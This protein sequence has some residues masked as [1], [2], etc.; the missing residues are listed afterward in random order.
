MTRIEAIL[1]DCQQGGY[2]TPTTTK[3][4]TM[5]FDGSTFDAARD[6]ARLGDQMAAVLSIM[7]D[8]KWRT[9]AGIASET[10]A[11]EASV[12]ARLRDLRKSRFGGHTVNREY[13]QRGLFQYQL[14]VSETEAV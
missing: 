6:S 4:A 13:L 12:S 2:C 3:E 11:P 14:L 8:G 9:L 1:R 10:N 5:R 7:A